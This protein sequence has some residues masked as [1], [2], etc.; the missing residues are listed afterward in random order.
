MKNNKTFTLIALIIFLQFFNINLRAD[1]LNKID[2]EELPAQDPFI[3]GN[4]TTSVSEGEINQ[5][6]SFPNDINGIRLIGTV[7]GESRNIALISTPDGSTRI[8]GENE[9]IFGDIQLL[10]ISLNWISVR[11]NA[12]ENYDININGQIMPQEGN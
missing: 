1:D 12:E 7:L 9:I 6:S 8:Y 5:V 2:E 4:A 3:S 11:F 10:D